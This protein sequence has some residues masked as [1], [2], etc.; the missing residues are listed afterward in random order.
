MS[1]D[2]FRRNA[3]AFGLGTAA[4]FSLM[5][6]ACSEPR[7]SDAAERLAADPDRLAK[8]QE[9]CR[10]GELEDSD[11]GCR[12]AAEA[13]RRRFRGDGVRYTPGGPAASAPALPSR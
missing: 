5:M 6:A 13:E 9:A 8:L 10:T 3:V 7:A 1:R 2:R 11:K 4:G 12:E